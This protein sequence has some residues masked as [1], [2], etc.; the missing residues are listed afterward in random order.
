IVATVTHESIESLGLHVGADAFALVKAS[1][2]ILVTEGDDARFSARNR[3]TGTISKI[4]PGAVNTE[5]VL[6]VSDGCSVVA[7]VTHDG[8][9][10]LGLLVGTRA[11]AIFKASSVIVG[12][13]A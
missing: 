7:I 12:V 13:P 8:S 6:D 9:A 4:Q 11:T 2:I 10:A 3:L 5:V 1:W